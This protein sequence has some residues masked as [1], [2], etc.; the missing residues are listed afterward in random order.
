MSE[1]EKRE[2]IEAEDVADEQAE[3]RRFEELAKIKAKELQLSE[4]LARIEPDCGKVVMTEQEL[5]QVFRLVDAE[6]G[7]C[8]CLYCESKQILQPKGE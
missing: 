5:A 2:Q 4:R 3:K 1:K 8:R 7:I 6:R